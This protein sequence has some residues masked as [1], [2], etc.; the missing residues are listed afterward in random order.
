MILQQIGIPTSDVTSYDVLVPQQAVWTVTIDMFLSFSEIGFSS[1]ND[2]EDYVTSQL[3]NDLFLQNVEAT[4]PPITGL[5]G[6]EQ[7][8]YIKTTHQPSGAPTLAPS[9]H[10]KHKSSNDDDD[11]DA[12]VI[13]GAVIGSILGVA[14]L[15]IGALMLYRHSQ[16]SKSSIKDSEEAGNSSFGSNNSGPASPNRYKFGSASSSGSMGKPLLNLDED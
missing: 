2:F 9:L 4:V 14:L 6:I 5:H 10:P 13:A 8:S 16:A 1:I 15:A 7:T 3:E 11:D 12:G